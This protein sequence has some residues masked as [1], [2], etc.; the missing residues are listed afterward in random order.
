[1]AYKSMQKYSKARSFL[2]RAVEI[3]QKSMPNHRDL[4]IYL[5][6]LESVKNLK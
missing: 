4:Q 1:M 6:N 3:A 5:E 2:E